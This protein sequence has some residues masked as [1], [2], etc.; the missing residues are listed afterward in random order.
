MEEGSEGTRIGGMIGEGVGGKGVGS[1]TGGRVGDS[2]SRR[3]LGSERF[4]LRSWG[5]NYY[6]S[7]SSLNK[8]I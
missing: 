1:I 7:S 2:K 8:L 4:D 3:G 5:V 6:A